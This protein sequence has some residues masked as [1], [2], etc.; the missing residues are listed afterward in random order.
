MPQSIEVHVVLNSEVVN[1]MNSRASVVG[2]MNGITS[3]VR[4]VYC[5]DHVEVKRV[6][7][8]LES[9]PDLSQ[10][11]ELDSTSQRVITH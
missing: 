3:D 8:E 9:L 11:S 5:A 2:V 7:S 4:V 6:S 10:L 1:P